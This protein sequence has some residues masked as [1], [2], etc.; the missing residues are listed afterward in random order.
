MA[1]SPIPTRLN[2]SRQQTGHHIG[3]DRQA[4]DQIELL[5]NKADARAHFANIRRE[6]AVVL[7]AAPIDQHLALR[8]RRTRGGARVIANHETCQVTQQCR[9]SGP[10]STDKRD[11]F[12]RHHLQIHTLECRVCAK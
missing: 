5:K 11:H 10:R 6:P 7:Y 12:T 1:C 9:L 2:A 3:N 4:A 8:Q